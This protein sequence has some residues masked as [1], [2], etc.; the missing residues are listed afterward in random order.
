MESYGNRVGP[1]GIVESNTLSPAVV[2]LLT[3]FVLGWL[4]TA[5]MAHLG[6]VFQSP[7]RGSALLAAFLLAIALGAKLPRRLASWLGRF[8]WPRETEMQMPVTLGDVKPDVQLLWTILATAA[9]LSGLAVAILP[10]VFRGTQWVHAA[11]LHRFFWMPLPYVLLT[12][13]I[14]F[15]VSLIPL[16]LIGFVLTCV[17]HLGRADGRCRHVPLPWIL[18]GAGSGVATITAPSH[19]MRLEQLVVLASVPMFVVAILAVRQSQ[20]ALRSTD[21]PID[22]ELPPAPASRDSL[23]YRIATTCVTV[24]TAG[25]V[26]VWVH[27]LQSQSPTFMPPETILA[28]MLG[29]S[30][31]GAGVVFRRGWQAA[32]ST[33]GF[34]T[35]CAVAGVANFAVIFCLAALEDRS[36]RLA[37]AVRIALPCLG[38]LA[39]AYVQARAHRTALVYSVNRNAAEASLVAQTAWAPAIVL[40]IIALAAPQGTQHFTILVAISL[41][42][43]AVGGWLVLQ[44]PADSALWRTVRGAVA[45]GSISLMAFLIPGAVT[46]WSHPPT[47]RPH[48]A[49]SKTAAPQPKTNP[50]KTDS[51]LAPNV[52]KTVS[53]GKTDNRRG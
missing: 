43:A 14:A 42:L 31:L 26:I 53:S 38:V 1:T 27:C 34:G 30:A 13:L 19:F 40:M 52:R 24:T 36:D 50:P 32:S 23:L 2:A 6:T 21:A 47:G 5:I 35:A 48:S 46:R 25:I 3:G 10:L 22:A 49:F 44:E 15:L 8:V 20:V 45:L 11:A 28:M 18:L 17:N 37:A 4:A 41:G 29:V 39:A 16:S 33:F 51:R 12:M 7:T 9:L